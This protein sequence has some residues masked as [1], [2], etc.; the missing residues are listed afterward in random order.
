MI[1]A[2]VY[3]ILTGILAG[4]LSAVGYLKISPYL[5]KRFNLSD[6]CGVNNLHG[7]PSILGCIISAIAADVL[8]VK[9]FK[10][11]TETK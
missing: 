3:A 1:T 9:T 4:L 7:M 8:N 2:P 10:N 6:T 11:I 5:K